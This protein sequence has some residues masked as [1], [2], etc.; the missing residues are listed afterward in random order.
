MR[1]TN[2]PR[3]SAIGLTIALTSSG[4]ARAQEPERAEEVIR[5][6]PP[7]SAYGVPQQGVCPECPPPEEADDG[8][9]SYGDAGVVELGG[10]VS[11]LWTEDVWTLNVSPSFGVFVID[12]LELS[13]Y[14]AVQHQNLRGDDGRRVSGTTVAVILEPSYHVPVADDVL[15]LFSGLG[16]GVGYDGVAAGF[17]VVPRI[18]ANIALGA[19]RMLNPALR[20]P[21][22]L[23]TATGEDGEDQFDTSVSVGFEI[24]YT[25]LY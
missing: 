3:V 8:L 24:G 25:T 22:I 7:A 12:Y 18:G 1:R 20:V 17:E 23:G 16:V 10:S 14:V 15:F 6:A 5:D 21:I 9:P 13:L 4:I 19:T 11:G 2:G